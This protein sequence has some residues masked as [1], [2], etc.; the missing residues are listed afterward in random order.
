[1]ISYLHYIIFKRISTKETNLSI[2]NNK[3][4]FKYILKDIYNIYK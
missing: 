4:V 2:Y 3:I 1:M